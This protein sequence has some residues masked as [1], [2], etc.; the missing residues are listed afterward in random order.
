M[1]RMNRNIF[2]RIAAPP[3]IIGLLLLASCLASLW[4]IDR[5]QRDLVRVLA[6]NVTALQAA[7]E[8]EIRLRQLRFH[9]FTYLIDPRA[10]RLP[11]IQADESGFE[12]ALAA[13]KQAAVT[14]EQ[15]RCVDTI[16][17]GYRRYR[18]EMEELRAE[19]SRSGRSTDFAKLADAHPIR[20]MVDPCQEL[21]RLNRDRI[22]RTSQ[23]SQRVGNQARIAMLVLG[24]VGPVSGVIM[25]YGI[26]RGLSRS[27]YKLS[28]RVQDM[29][30]HLDQ[31]VASVVLAADGDI[32]HLD[33]QLE[34]VVARVEEV[35]KHLQKQ[36]RDM[37][38]A[39]Q[40]AAV[41]QLAA[42]VAHEVRN[43]LT[44]LKLLVESA[45][46]SQNQ[47]P[48]SVADLEVMHREIARLEQTVQSFLEFAR[49][50][51]LRR[52]PEDLRGVVTQALELVQARAR[53][54]GVTMHVMLP[55]ELLEAD[56]D[57]SQFSNVIV[58]LLINALEAMP[59]GGN[60]EIALDR[61]G[62][63]GARFE[64]RDTGVGIAPAMAGRLFAPFASTKPTG[65]GLGLSICRRIV[66]EHGGAITGGNRPGGGASFTIR[67]PIAKTKE[68][69]A[70]ALGH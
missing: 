19:I 48:V 64:I 7:Q 5:L 26:A 47:K 11:A 29:A 50:P 8:L 17:A 35:G 12:H 10:D 69:H 39:E 41:G 3:V 36:E 44:S 58:N 6:E 45:L 66:E 55:D 23:D 20:H 54:Q 60:L 56:L 68:C 62:E 27:I 67:V 37:L 61:D 42:S 57:G 2:L 34:H 52:R 14:P 24:V 32:Q 25:G 21:L 15:R 46:R 63:N 9:S 33:R 65:T 40:L 22:D 30:H 1:K 43:P 70:A 53:Q 31:D 13:A 16:E 18:A 49:P 51:E 38:R 28:L 59:K 4:Y